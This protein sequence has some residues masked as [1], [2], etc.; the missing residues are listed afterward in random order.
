MKNVL[1]L[2]A[3]GNIAPHIIPGLER[4]YNLRLA[5]IRRHPGGKPTMHVD[6][7]DYGQVLEA[8]RGMDAIMNWNRRPQGSG[9]EFHRVGP[10]R[11]A[12]DESGGG[13]GHHKDPPHGS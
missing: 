3:S 1:L 6:M 5:D 8:A 2:G 10:G 11:L 12:R 4:H 13:T 7:G 9:G